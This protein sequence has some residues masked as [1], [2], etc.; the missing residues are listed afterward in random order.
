LTVADPQLETLRSWKA[1]V[2]VVLGSGLNAIPTENHSPE[3][4]SYR[5]F[6]AIPVPTVAGHSGE[7]RLARIADVPVVLACGRVH[8]YE[9]HSAEKVTSIVRLLAAIG[10]EQIILTNA[11]GSLHEKFSPGSWM[12]INDHLNLSG[13]SPL[14]GPQF[15][16]MSGTYSARMCDCFE[17][18]A[19][20]L[21]MTLRAGVYASVRGPQ[22]ETA[23]EVKMLRT[24]G[25]DAVG[26][27][28]VLEAIQARALGME[29]AGLS[30]ITN[31]AAGAAVSHAE[32]LETGKRAAADFW[33]LFR[34]AL[35]QL[36]A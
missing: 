8:L 12:L 26:M 14:N 36:V 5:G 34:A 25:A 10:T 22:Y 33:R 15:I 7:F 13:T 3:I 27:S 23:A 35:P 20:N 11:A 9:G 29:V 32:V 6:P 17:V 21:Q 18:A 24:L 1:R 28:T 4:V 2:A 19:T 30:C 31:F 16:D